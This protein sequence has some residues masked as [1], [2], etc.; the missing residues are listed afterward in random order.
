MKHP[1][2]RVFGLVKSLSVGVMY[3]EC[4]DYVAQEASLIFK[5]KPRFN[6]VGIWYGKAFHWHQQV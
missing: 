4:D 1:Y 2:R 5:Y 6:R 3:K